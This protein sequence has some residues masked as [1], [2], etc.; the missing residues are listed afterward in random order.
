MALNDTGFFG[1]YEFPKQL[2]YYKVE[3]DKTALVHSKTLDQAEDFHSVDEE[4]ESKLSELIMGFGY[5][6]PSI[7]IQDP[8]ILNEYGAMD[9]TREVVQQM[10]LKRLD[11]DH[12]LTIWKTTTVKIITST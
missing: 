11:S 2:S 1:V 8:V 4:V 9:M 5:K 10:E 12:L 3:I 6:N 7:V